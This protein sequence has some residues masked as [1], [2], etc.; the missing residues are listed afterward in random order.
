M[1]KVITILAVLA[2]VALGVLNLTYDFGT[3]PDMVHPMA[4]QHVEWIKT[5]K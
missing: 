4:N 5:G 3:K 1:Q 2:V